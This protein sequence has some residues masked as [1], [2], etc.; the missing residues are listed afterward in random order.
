MLVYSGIYVY[1]DNM[2][3]NVELSGL[4]LS[5]SVHCQ[6]EPVLPWRPPSALGSKNFLKP[7]LWA[8]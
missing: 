4:N 8:K 3:G 6:N 5:V 1:I 2:N 7:K